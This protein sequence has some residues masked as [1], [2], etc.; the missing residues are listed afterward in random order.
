MKEE[1]CV[2]T[3]GRNVPE[4]VGGWMDGQREGKEEKKK[5]KVK[6]KKDSTEQTEKKH[7]NTPWPNEE[8]QPHTGPWKGGE[9][10]G[11]RKRNREQQFPGDKD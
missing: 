10:E 6:K 2:D 8:T 4:G 11:K 3:D 1:I 9:R 5:H 7:S